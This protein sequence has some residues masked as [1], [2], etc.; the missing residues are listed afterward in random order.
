MITREEAL[1]RVLGTAWQLPPV[2]VALGHAA[3]RVLAEDVPSDMDMP[4]F[5]KSS[6]DGYACRA[7]DAFMPLRV[8][9]HVAAGSLPTQNIGP[10]TC[11][12]IMT[13]A[14]V[15]EGADC[16]LVVEQ[17]ESDAGGTIR[18][19]GTEPKSNICRRG[20][21]LR[22]GDRVLSRGM[23]LTSAHLP[24]LAS[25]GCTR[26]PVAAQPRV[27]IIATGTELVPP[28]ETP[29]P[30]KIRN[31]NSVQIASLAAAAGARTT[32]L[33]IV[34]DDWDA[35]SKAWEAA[36]AR[37]DVVISTGG[38]SM[39]DYDL[40]PDI[41]KQHG[42]DIHFE[43]V[44]IQPGKPVLFGTR[45]NKACFGLSGN[46]VSSFLQFSLFAA[47]FLWQLQGAAHRPR[48]APM[49]LGETFRR[50]RAGREAFVPVHLDENHYVLPIEFHGSA[51]IHS[52]AH[53]DGLIA[54]PP[55][56]TVLEAGGTVT[57]HFLPL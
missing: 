48:T 12:K 31:S 9:E 41:L 17:V 34:T 24:M 40:V 54:F 6:M 29:A 5:D 39:G 18:F 52:L 1:R 4:P 16:I 28:N 21:D 49:V 38:V 2:A 22:R 45:E 7:V 37:H 26:P 51:H 8:L 20:E 25:V 55:D 36:L 19:T 14:P 32:D 50:K 3:G 44:A 10:G 47:P 27:A 35:L 53:A 42:F 11:S 46:P 43:K 56:E 15:P 30:G 13:G 33:G 23:R 57:V